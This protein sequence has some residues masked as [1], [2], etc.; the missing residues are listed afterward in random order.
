MVRDRWPLRVKNSSG[1]VIPPFSVMRV[2]NWSK[3]N[4]EILYTVAKPDS[5]YR[6]Q[7]LVSGP[8]AIGSGSSDEGLA[9][10]L[11]NG[12]PVYYNSGT[13]AY[14]E[15]WGPT[16]GQW[17]LT[18][19]RPGFHVQGAATSS[20]N[21]KNLL[22]AT[23]IPP[24]EV[25]VKNDSGGAVSAGSSATMS[26]FGGSAGTTDIG[27]DVTLTNGSSVSWSTDKY[28]WGTLDAGGLIFG[29]PHQT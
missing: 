22:V 11:S 24:G 21:S 10:F 1:E 7:Y 20:F 16:S 29:A 28:G 5:T 23:Q 25:R 13:P 17:Y 18:Q 15:R 8:F 14:G 12:G 6:W 19:H 9:S 2:T 4:N 26:M 3:S 27:F